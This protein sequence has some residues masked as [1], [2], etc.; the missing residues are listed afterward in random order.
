MDEMQA[1]RSGSFLSGAYAQRPQ[2]S[3]MQVG[4]GRGGFSPNSVLE[5]NQIVKNP[6]GMS[7]ADRARQPVKGSGQ[8]LNGQS[9]DTFQKRLWIGSSPYRTFG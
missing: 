2:F 7:A 8:S 1:G 3:S 5:Q 6:N 4:A 9:D